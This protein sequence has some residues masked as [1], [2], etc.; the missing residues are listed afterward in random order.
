MTATITDTTQPQPLTPDEIPDEHQ[1]DF[2]PGVYDGV[3]NEVYHDCG[4]I[5]CS[6]LKQAKKSVLHYL[7]YLNSEPKDTK[8]LRIGNGV[9]AAVLEPDRFQ[10]EYIDYKTPLEL[11]N[12]RHDKT[13]RLAAA[14]KD[15]ETIADACNVKS[16]TIEGYL[17]DDDVQTMIEYYTEH[18]PDE[19]PDV[20][21]SELV[22]VL[23]MRDAV[24][25]HPG[26]QWL[27]N[28]SEAAAERSFWWIDR[29]TGLP[30]RCR[31]DW[32][33]WTDLGWVAVDIK[34]C[35]DA[36]KFGFRRTVTRRDYHLQAP[37][38]TDGI[39]QH[40]D[41]GVAKFIFLAV[42]KVDIDRGET[43]KVKLWELEDE[44]IAAGRREYRSGLENIAAYYRDPEMWTGYGGP[45]EW[46]GQLP[47]PGWMR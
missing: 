29:R 24:G 4:A 20:S 5:S 26:A 23:A 3:P 12:W 22:E 6:G 31:P 2:Q 34:T 18:P 21:E 19:T 33:C 38:Y 16:S 10:S 45:G 11:S 44:F 46:V 41:A 37:F 13:A 9:H 15:L 25:S 47:A 1:P 7:D 42:E 39:N 32:L 35:R 28:Q 43:P 27:L 36:S 8:D 30:C 17:E 40:L 14:G